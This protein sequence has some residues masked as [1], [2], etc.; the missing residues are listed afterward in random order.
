MGAKGMNISKNFTF[1]EWKCHDNCGQCIIIQPLVD[2]MQKFRDRVGLIVQVH[3]VN[4]CRKHN[5]EV[6]GVD[7]GE[8]LSLHVS[9]EACDFNV[10]DLPMKKLHAIVLASDDI[11]TG[12]VGLYSWGVHVDVGEKRFWDERKNKYYKE[13]V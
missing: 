5:K 9:G 7:D 12:G 2:M 1:D 3:D 11:F 8:K 6:G 13:T 4:R 10:P